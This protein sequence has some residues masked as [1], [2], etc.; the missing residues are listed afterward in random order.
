MITIKTPEENL[1][2]LFKFMQERYSRTD[3]K[4][5]ATLQFVLDYQGTKICYY[6]TMDGGQLS[7]TKGI[8]Q[9]PF[10]T[11]KCK[12]KDW[13]DVTSGKL[14]PVLGAITGKLKFKGDTSLFN[15]LS[16]DNNKNNLNVHNDPIENYEEDPTKEWKKP[17]NVLVVN[18]SPNGEKGYTYFYLNPL[19]Q[20]MKDSGCNV[21]L[22]NLTQ[23]SVKSCK[24]CFHC[25]LSDT[26]K[27]II[28]DDMYEYYDN[29][30]LYDIIVFAFPLYVDGVPGILKNFIDRLIVGLYPFMVM[31]KG[32]IRHPRRNKNRVNMVMFSTSG[33][34][35]IEHFDSVR[36]HF[37]AIS[38]NS[39]MPLI[40][41][42]FRPEG[43]NLYNN[44]SFYVKLVEVID[45][46][47]QAGKEIVE[48]G[49]VNKKKLKT[50]SQDSSSHKDFME[51]SNA[52]WK[53]NIDT[54]KKEN[55]N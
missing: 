52:F 41:E 28:K 16:S 51:G 10:V 45:S 43:M 12:Y 6:L 34:P 8:S 48:N 38:H 32:K 5:N 9:N 47:K 26:G 17:D 21:Q 39:H 4:T 35:G 14:N 46:L 33:F 2:M 1:E 19:I 18:G 29:D 25:W 13:L 37:K 15:K 54:Y 55:C 40:A 22:M 11:L 3:D 30:D 50:I 31:G 27:C 20:G 44:P 23:K 42:I 24:G 53:D 7:Y 49:K 36:S